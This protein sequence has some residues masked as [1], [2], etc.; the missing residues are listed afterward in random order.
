MRFET[1]EQARDAARAA[2][3]NWSDQ[4]SLLNEPPAG[5]G[6]DGLGGS[7]SGARPGQPPRPVPVDTGAVASHA[8]EDVR[9]LTS[10]PPAPLA[11][12]PSERAGL[13]STGRTRP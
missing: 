9:P 7:L 1:Y 11:D 5:G 2:W 13:T 10:V 3:A 6:T 4:L 12:L 8:T